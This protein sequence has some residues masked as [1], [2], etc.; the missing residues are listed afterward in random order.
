MTATTE[1]TAQLSLESMPTRLYAVTP[2]K[3][4]N[5]SD[6][7]RKFRFVYLQRLQK[8]PAWAHNS[9]GAAVHAALKQWWDLPVRERTKES[10]N[11]LVTKNWSTEGFRDPDQANAWRSRAGELAAQYVANLDPEK[12]PL[13]IERTV[14][15][16]VG[17][18]TVSGRVDRI[19]SR[20]NG[21]LEEAVVVDYKTGRR[22]LSSDDARASQALALYAVATA[23][24]L[25]RSCTRVELHHLPS[26]SIIG[27]DHTNET[28]QRHVSRANNIAIEARRAEEIW[29]AGLDVQADRAGQSSVGVNPDPEVD[30][31]LPP[32]P[33][34][35]CAWC[36]FR[37]H[38]AEGRDAAPGLAPWA[39]LA[40]EGNGL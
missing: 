13:G 38:C 29:K 4:A 1:Q 28:L 6:C 25:R 27:W 15:S 2:T 8:G 34:P 36:D 22:V 17:S 31:V 30:A 39:G 3:L 12:Q 23:R 20:S 35:G 26:Q 11:K 7:P 14:G 9:L 37:R 18:M 10:A 32:K 19:D 16:P 5:W 40:D 24:T 21:L 33:G